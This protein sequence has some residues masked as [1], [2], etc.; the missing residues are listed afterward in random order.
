M[1]NDIHSDRR[2][3]MTVQQRKI[4]ERADDRTGLVASIVVTGVL[5]AASFAAIV[6]HAS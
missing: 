1:F 4:V 6:P 2:N 5:I 3:D